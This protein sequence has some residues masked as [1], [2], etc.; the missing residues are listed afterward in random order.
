[1]GSS[2]GMNEVKKHSMWSRMMYLMNYY[3]PKIKMM[4]K[5]LIMVMMMLMIDAL[6]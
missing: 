1:M 2:G 6:M 5:M 3:S 4:I